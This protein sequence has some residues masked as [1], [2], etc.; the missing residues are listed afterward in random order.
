MS[1]QNDTNSIVWK[2]VGDFMK[3]T[4]FLEIRKTDKSI[5]KTGKINAGHGHAVYAKTLL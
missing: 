2:E 5:S 3:R 4:V 1:E